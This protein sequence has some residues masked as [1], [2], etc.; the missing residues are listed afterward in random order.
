MYFGSTST[1]PSEQNFI[2]APFRSPVIPMIKPHNMASSAVL[3]VTVPTVNP[4]IARP[5]AVTL[6]DAPP[7][8]GMAMMPPIIRAAAPNFDAFLSFDYLLIVSASLPVTLIC[9]SLFSR[10]RFRSSLVDTVIIIRD[11]CLFVWSTNFLHGEKVLPRT[12]VAI[13]S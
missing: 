10:A 6:L 3:I 1:V 12:I 8:N 9:F 7:V 5:I 2:F 4:V 13:P 11:R